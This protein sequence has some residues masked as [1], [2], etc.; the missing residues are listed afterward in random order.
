VM[1]ALT[2]LLYL[3]TGLA[4]AM[5]SGWTAELKSTGDPSLNVSQARVV[6]FLG[7]WMNLIMAAGLPFSAASTWFFFRRAGYNLA[8]HLIFNTYVYAHVCLLFVAFS[9]PVLGGGG[10]MTVMGAYTAASLA[11]SAWAGV[12]FFGGSPVRTVLRALVANVVG[13][14]AYML[15]IFIGTLVAGILYFL[16]LRP[17]A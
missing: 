8:E 15:F 9:I 1:A 14:L 16:L 10:I 11:Y 3:N 2:T 7:K 5:A 4:D 6:E 17:G 12:G 13:Y